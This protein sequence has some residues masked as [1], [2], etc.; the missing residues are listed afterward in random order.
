V[1]TW[2]SVCARRAIFT[3]VRALAGTHGTISGY[4]VLV[5]GIRVLV[6]DRNKEHVAPVAVCLAAAAVIARLRAV[7]FCCIVA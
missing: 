2:R 3:A 7:S 4:D 5:A 1:R 6:A